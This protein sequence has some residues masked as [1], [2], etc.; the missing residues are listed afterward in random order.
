MSNFRVTLYAVRHTV[1]L[2]IFFLSLSTHYSSFLVEHTPKR[3]FT[4]FKEGH[5]LPSKTGVSNQLLFEDYLLLL[6]VL[7]HPYINILYSKA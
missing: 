7:Y 5:K 1:L 4:F 3:I 6:K 2:A